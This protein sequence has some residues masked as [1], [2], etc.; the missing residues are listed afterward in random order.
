M[1]KSKIETLSTEDMIKICAGL[2]KEGVLFT[3][4][5]DSMTWVIILTGGY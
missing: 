2:T 5:R 3:C 4:K 1:D